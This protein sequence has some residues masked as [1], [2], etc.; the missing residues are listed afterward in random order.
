MS[1]VAET[2]SP[3]PRPNGLVWLRQ[4]LAPFPGRATWTL[5]IVVSVVLVTIISMALQ[6]PSTSVSAYMVFFVMKENRVVTMLMGIMLFLGTAIGVGLSL[7]L[8]RYTFDYPQL[9]IPVMAAVVFA[10]MYL[11]RAFVIG[12]LGWAIGFIVGYTQATADTI[13]NTD[14][15]VRALLWTWV[16]GGI[17]PVAVTVVISETLLPGKAW[18]ELVDAL[19]QRLD[20]ASSALERAIKEGAFGG[21]KDAVLLDNA[22]R[23]SGK[24]LKLLKLA[25]IKSKVVKQ[26][27]SA[28]ASA[29]AAS[30]RLVS[31]IAAL[32]L[33]DR[34][35][36]SANDRLCAEALIGE[37]SRLRRAVIEHNFGYSGESVQDAAELLEMR[38]LQLAAVSFRDGLAGKEL[39]TKGAVEA[40]KHRGL[41]VPDAFTNPEYTRFAF[42]VT[43]TS[44]SCYI[45]YTGLDW[46]GIHTAFITCTIIALENLGATTRK[47]AL[48]L[49]GCSVGGLLGFLTIMYLLPHMVSIVSLCFV[50]AA[51]AALAGWVATGSER[52]SYAGLQIAFAFFMCI[53][54]GFAPKVEFDTIRDR[55]VGIVLGIVV[56]SVVFRYIWPER[57][58]DKFRAGLARVLRD[59][60]RLLVVPSVGGSQ[61]EQQA[62]SR[63]RGEIT[64]E[65]DN[66]RGLSGLAAFEREMDPVTGLPV[67]KLEA[68]VH[69]AQGLY[70]VATSLSGETALKEWVRVETSEKEAEAALRTSAAEELRRTANFMES[71]HHQ[72]SDELED[73]Q[74]K[75]ERAVTLT[76]GDDR[77][78]LVRELVAQVQQLA[79]T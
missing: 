9:R 13:P 10:A 40:P 31:A 57:A 69:H 11:S 20:A 45:I 1:A 34:H 53:F 25:S 42:K 29:I 63:L 71:G 75:W 59:L 2:L 17:L 27:H 4:E 39:P 33:M 38:E 12:P 6:V 32:E 15:L 43:L 35:P 72:E 50:A 61:T 47:G 74:N 36:L 18:A 44:M 14:L 48:R 55:F 70:V 73:S 78:R 49:V 52:I 3:L 77:P 41:F 37:I 66:V 64:K 21:H 60:A 62:V 58:G 19:T 67:S 28:I 68:M 22:T 51:G 8:Y 65:F 46:P 7:F 16:F 26:H 56:S 76:A 5:R 24:L 23:G 79:R 30:E 54:H